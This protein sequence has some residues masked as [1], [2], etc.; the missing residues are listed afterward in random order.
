MVI[1]VNDLVGKWLRE[2]TLKEK[3]LKRSEKQ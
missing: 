3:D 1:K 2:E